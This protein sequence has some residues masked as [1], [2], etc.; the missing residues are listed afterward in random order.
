MIEN[1]VD[2]NFFEL[3]LK[4]SEFI[5]TDDDLFELRESIANH[6]IEKGTYPF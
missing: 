4:L 1:L 6:L 3:C 2:C 5:E